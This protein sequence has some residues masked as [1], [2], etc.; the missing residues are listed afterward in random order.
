MAEEGRLQGK[1]TQDIKGFG[2]YVYSFKTIKTNV[3]GTP[4]VFFASLLTGPI[5]VEL[6]AK[7][8][9]ARGSQDTQ[10]LLASYAGV[11]S[12]VVDSVED[13]ILL[14]KYLGLNIKNLKKVGISNDP[15]DKYIYR[16]L[17]N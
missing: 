1:V 9:E 7:D 3:R 8:K 16:S 6:K 13:W 17:K 14:K 12:F 5:H 11:R 4:D 15:F 2:K 10:M